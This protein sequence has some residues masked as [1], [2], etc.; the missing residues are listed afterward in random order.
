MFWMGKHIPAGPGVPAGLAAD[1]QV[2]PL[3]TGSMLFRFG[4]LLGSSPEATT[5]QHHQQLVLGVA[6]SRS[7]MGPGTSMKGLREVWEATPEAQVSVR[8]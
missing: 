2:C 5:S 1:T 7:R 3:L 6:L 4:G 8:V